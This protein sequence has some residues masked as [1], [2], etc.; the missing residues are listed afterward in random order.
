MVYRA[1]EH[2][3]PS[4]D[5]T[6]NSRPFI[7]V[8]YPYAFCVASCLVLLLPSQSDSLPACQSVSQYPHRPHP[9]RISST[10][11]PDCRDPSCKVSKP[12]PQRGEGG[13]LP[14]AGI[15]QRGK[16]A[17]GRITIRPDC[18]VC[19]VFTLFPLLLRSFFRFSRRTGNV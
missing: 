12:R 16:R 15:R 11:L 3:R 17:Q 13:R 19:L 9:T 14:L 4:N 8:P 18:C 6:P 5:F 10:S 1:G 7:S 2:S